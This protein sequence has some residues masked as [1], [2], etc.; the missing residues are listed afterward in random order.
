MYESVEETSESIA[1][2]YVERH[3]AA[4]ESVAVMAT[5]RE[6]RL[7]KAERLR[8]WADKRDN[9]AAIHSQAASEYI[10]NTPLGQPVLVGHHSENRHRRQIE[11]FNH[12][13]QA[14][15]DNGDKASEM[16]QRAENIEDAA[17]RA[18][19]DDDLDAIERLQEKID[20]IN[21]NKA[22][23]L[24]FNKTCRRGQPDT[25][26][27]TEELRERYVEL[28]GLGYL[29]SYGGLPPAGKSTRQLELRLA[30][31]KRERGMQ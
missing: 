26:L 12:N 31:L 19:Y 4:S 17:N 20:K 22:R 6:R 15:I 5:Y 10:A 18:I 16:R 9:K 8:E 13:M 3:N 29:N 1:R 30:R 24:A 28:K 27:L 7:A 21:D 11:R 14:S 25:G 23:I 2:S